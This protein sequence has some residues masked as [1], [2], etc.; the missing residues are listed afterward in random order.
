MRFQPE[1]AAES[2]K[3]ASAKTAER[4]SF[5]VPHPPAAA[6]NFAILHFLYR[7]IPAYP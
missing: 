4:H 7:F 3:H 6:C 2:K 5:T 1:V